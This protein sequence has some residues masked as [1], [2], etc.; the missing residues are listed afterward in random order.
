MQ[1]KSIFSKFQT[2][3][4][5]ALIY[6]IFQ[7]W[8]CSLLLL[9]GGRW[10]FYRFETRTENGTPR[11]REE[12][13]SQRL[14]KLATRK[15]KKRTQTASMRACVCMSRG[16]RR[17][18]KKI[19]VNRCRWNPL[20]HISNIFTP[21]LYAVTQQASIGFFIGVRLRDKGI[22]RYGIKIYVLNDTGTE[23]KKKLRITK[24]NDAIICSAFSTN[25]FKTVQHKESWKMPLKAKK[26]YI[27]IFISSRRGRN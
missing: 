6:L 19:V 17:R 7:F 16:N 11:R 18:P 2:G 20:C 3:S 22:H 1:A 4:R 25:T 27:Y 12:K 24:P 15:A 13:E 10:T 5:L 23:W 26:K 9:F 21:S 14:S 8:I